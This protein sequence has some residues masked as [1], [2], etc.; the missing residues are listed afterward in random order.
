MDIQTPQ[1]GDGGTPVKLGDN[2]EVSDIVQQARGRADGFLYGDDRAIGDRPNWASQDSQQ[3]YRYATVNN[4]PGTAEEI[5]QTWSGHSTSLREASENL[6]N[7]I[8]EL[9]AAWIG[10]G[11]GAAQGSL[12]AIA[13]SSAQASEAADTMSQRLKQQAAAAAELKKM[14]QPQ[15]FDPAK[16]T[17]AMLAGGPAA[18]TK[19][20]KEQFDAAREVKAQQVAYLEA[21]TAAMSE[22]DGSTPS[23]GPESIG[24][25][26]GGN[27]SGL[28]AGGVGSVGS[29]GM[30]GG[31]GFAGPFAG[32][33]S[34]P[35]IGGP[36]GA[37]NAVAASGL[38]Q[39][40]H[41]GPQH[42][43]GPSSPVHGA[44]AAGP[45]QGATT[46]SGQAAAAAGSG[47]GLSAGQALGA[48]VAG[49]ALGLGGAKALAKGARSGSTK[50]SSSETSASANQQAASAA[51]VQ[52]Q[53]QGMVAPGGTIGG[54]A[55]QAPMGGAPMGGMGAGAGQQEQEKEHTHASF[56]IEPDPDDAFGA[57]VATP[58]PVLGAWGPD[59][60]EE[61]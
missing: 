18:M 22:I 21:Y 51:S 19:D 1:P 44:P 6:Y 53:N 33:G 29:Y 13:N 20:M 32:L 47:G 7:A 38:G 15:E 12:V 45:A 5:G 3:L 27:A 2:A 60:D 48:A 37:D 23:F 28:N 59:D 41:G 49:G 35:A 36:G 17:A 56:L 14:P 50:Q 43:G 39:G 52:P 26:P 8:S 10:Q 42:A 24:L 4:V 25:K 55:Q 30:P 46:G 11:A 9:G 34:T 61:R 58:P 57:T 31:A 54:G 16:E 40:A